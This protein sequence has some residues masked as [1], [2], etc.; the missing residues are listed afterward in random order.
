MTASEGQSNG[1]NT[2]A[3]Y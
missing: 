2:S 1:G 3:S